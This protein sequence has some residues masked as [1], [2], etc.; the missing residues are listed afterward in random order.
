MNLSDLAPDYIRSIAAYQPGKPI[1]DV[2]RELGDV[3]EP[4]AQAGA[5]SLRLLGPRLA[6]AC[7]FAQ[8]PYTN[9]S[10]SVR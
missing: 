5:E 4:I 7:H 1:S 6:V 3:G 8:P 10:F 2:A 9:R